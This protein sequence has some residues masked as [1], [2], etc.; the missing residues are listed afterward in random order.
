MDE[1]REKQKR[2]TQRYIL[3]KGL[4]MGPEPPFNQCFVKKEAYA[5][6]KD[7]RNI[8]M[9]KPY[10]KIRYA[11]YMYPVGK[12]LKEQSWYMFRKPYKIADKVAK[13]CQS[14]NFIHNGD[15]SRQDGHKNRPLRTFNYLFLLAFYHM[16]YHGEI[17][18]ICNSMLNVLSTTPMFGNDGDPR[19]HY[20]T[21]K[22]TQFSGGMDTSNFNTLDLSL[23]V[24]YAY[25]LKLRDWDR[26]Y[27][28]LNALAVCAGDDSVTGNL[29]GE[30]LLESA[31]FFGHDLKLERVDR[32]NIG[33]SFL[34][35]DYSPAVWEG[36]PNSCTDI[37]RCLSKLHTTVNL[38]SFTWLEK[39]QQKF[40]SLALT[41][42]NTFLIRDMLQVYKNVGGTLMADTD[43]RVASYW[44]RYKKNVQYPNNFG[45]WMEQTIKIDLVLKHFYEYLDNITNLNE[46]KTLPTVYDAQPTPHKCM[47]VA[48][49]DGDI[50][51]TIENSSGAK[52]HPPEINLTPQEV[53]SRT[54]QYR[55]LRRSLFSGILCK[56]SGG[57]IKY[58]TGS[59]GTGVVLSVLD[60][61]M[62]NYS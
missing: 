26:A 29:E 19:S 53:I 4:I 52:Q 37:V 10:F 41:D 20:F 15:L 6:V 5:D 8:T 33:V 34:A 13:I 14:S 40:S 1:V 47:D 62:H 21:S 16:E 30:Y 44:S 46:F 7:P 31:K 57:T 43:L 27:E 61:V 17:D 11:Q 59:L 42:G 24:F 51:E 25:Y 22:L 3:E 23:L 38:N 35:R 58:K 9:Q 60:F 48:I 55:R 2:P 18:N 28:A 49:N 32:G 36:S 39:L 50:I 12:F 45:D 56:N 54:I